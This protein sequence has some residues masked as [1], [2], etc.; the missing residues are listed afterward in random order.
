[1]LSYITFNSMFTCSVLHYIMSAYKINCFFLKCTALHNV[2]RTS[3]YVTFTL[4]CYRYAT[5]TMLPAVTV[6]S[7]FV[8]KPV[9]EESHY[10]PLLSDVTLLCV[11]LHCITA[12]RI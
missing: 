5:T 4:Q 12:C 11:T 1:M 8:S 10:G 6:F 9:C 7:M 3:N 2:L